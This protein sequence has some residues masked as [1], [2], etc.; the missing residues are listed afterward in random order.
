M[1]PIRINKFLA[2]AGICSRR[3]A[4]KIIEAGRVKIDGEI[5]ANGSK[6]GDGQTVTLDG[7]S[8]FQ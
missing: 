7:G 1:E 8:R 4:D 6:V 3:D 5:A 2:E